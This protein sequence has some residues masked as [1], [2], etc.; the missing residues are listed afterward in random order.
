MN[1]NLS[2]YKFVGD[3]RQ[4][5]KDT[6]HGST[7]V[8]TINGDFRTDTDVLNPVIEIEPTSTSTI[9]KILKECNYA[10]IDILGRYYYIENM[11]AQSGNRI[12][13]SLKVDVLMTWKA[14]ILTLNQ[15]IVERNGEASNSNLF[16]DDSEIH[17]Y[18]NPHICTYKF[19]YA[20]GSLEFN[21]G[22]YVLAVAGG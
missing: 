11:Q 5:N 4:L 17:L 7:L 9:A 18:N 19:S 21:S 1:T 10:Y 12:R 3:K 14:Q 2:L 6:S 16:L 20:S 15:G 8:E 13:L 22:S